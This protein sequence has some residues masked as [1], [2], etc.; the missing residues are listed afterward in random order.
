MTTTL[1][2]AAVDKL[3]ELRSLDYDNIGLTAVA[4]TDPQEEPMPGNPDVSRMWTIETDFPYAGLKRITVVAT[5][6]N[7][8]FGANRSL[9]LV[10]FKTENLV[11]DPIH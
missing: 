11:S 3:E 2:A 7:T 5:M 1:T 6:M 9:T 8:T 10:A 4:P